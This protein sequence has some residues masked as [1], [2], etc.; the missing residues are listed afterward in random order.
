MIMEDIPGRLGVVG[1]L[2]GLGVDGGGQVTQGGRGVA[3]QDGSH[4]SSYPL[5][6]PPLKQ[7][8]D[9]VVVAFYRLERVECHNH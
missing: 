9:S 4:P 5:P 1:V 8:S 7:H 3:A 6:Q 2:V